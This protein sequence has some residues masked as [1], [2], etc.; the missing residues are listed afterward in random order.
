MR[1][2]FT[3]QDVKP[4]IKPPTKEQDEMKTIGKKKLEWFP[5]KSEAD[6]YVC[7]LHLMGYSHAKVDRTDSGWWAIRGE[8]AA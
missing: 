1:G 7:A 8:L 2:P 3:G 4:K 6:A 5:M